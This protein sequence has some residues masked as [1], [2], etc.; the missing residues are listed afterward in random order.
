MTAKYLGTLTKVNFHTYQ[1]SD[2][3]I[4]PLSCKIWLQFRKHDVQCTK[5]GTYWT[6]LVI[7]RSKC[8]QVLQ[9]STYTG[10]LVQG[11]CRVASQYS[12]FTI[13]WIMI[14]Q[15]TD[16]MLT[17][18]YW[19][20][21]CGL[22]AINSRGTHISTVVYTLFNLGWEINLLQHQQNTGQM[23]SYSEHTLVIRLTT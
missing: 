15:H 8:D 21:N 16:S 9:R 2:A 5:M 11:I 10:T 18:S 14:F 4:G 17:R 23:L 22:T 6:T 7:A 20:R 12:L 1:Y 19:T 13:R 3:T